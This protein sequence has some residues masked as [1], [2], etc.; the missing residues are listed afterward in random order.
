[1]RIRL[2]CLC[3]EERRCP[4]QIQSWL[5]CFPGPP[6][7][8]G[9]TGLLLLLNARG[10][11]IGSWGAGR[12]PA[13]ACSSIPRRWVTTNLGPA[14]S[15]PGPSQAP[16]LDVNA[17]SHLPMHPPLRL[18]CSDRPEG[19]VL[20]CLDPPS[21]Q[22]VSPL[23]IEGRA[24]QYKVLPFGL[25]LSPCVFTK[26]VEAAFVPLRERGIPVLN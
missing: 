22:T 10:W 1:M 5:L 23:C 13:A 18:V 21:K 20:S 15:E 24:L 12:S 8:S 25:S 11:T 19:R 6:R 2:R 17:E 16:V 7:A 14:R 9:C 26:V 4:S 3:Q